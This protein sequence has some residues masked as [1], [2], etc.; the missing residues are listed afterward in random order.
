MSDGV[1]KTLEAASCNAGIPGNSLIVSLL[2]EQ[3]KK[4]HGYNNNIASSILKRIRQVQYDLF[5]RTA[6]DNPRSDVAIA[7]RKRDDMTLMI[8]KFAQ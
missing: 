8:Y 7:N 5:Q 6:R 1:Y 2:D 4:Q 3:V